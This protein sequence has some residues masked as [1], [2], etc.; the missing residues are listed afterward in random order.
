MYHLIILPD[1][2]IMYHS[3]FNLDV[4]ATEALHGF[5]T[6]VENLPCTKL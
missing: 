4:V 3:S 1:S 6:I 2:V 5:H